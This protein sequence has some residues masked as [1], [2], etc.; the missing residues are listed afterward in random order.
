MGKEG[1]V[2]MIRR[3]KREQAKFDTTGRETLVH[4]L[5]CIEIKNLEA[6][7]YSGKSCIF[8]GSLQDSPHTHLRQSHL[9]PTI[10]AP[11]EVIPQPKPRQDGG[12][13]THYPFQP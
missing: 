3:E 10:D 6:K 7:L 5:L 11:K 12:K 13:C 1:G 4:E 8:A 2:K 9:L